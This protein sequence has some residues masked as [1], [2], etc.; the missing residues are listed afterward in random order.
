MAPVRRS[1]PAIR[2]TL[3]PPKLVGLG[4][5]RG[6]GVGGGGGGPGGGGGGGGGEGGGGGGGGAGGG[7]VPHLLLDADFIL[8]DEIESGKGMKMK[9]Y[10]HTQPI[11]QRGI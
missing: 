3:R 8:P 6:T 1:P 10:V 9:A 4:R 5:G 2:A 11:K 7:K